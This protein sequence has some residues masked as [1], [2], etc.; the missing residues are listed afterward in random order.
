[1]SSASQAVARVPSKPALRRAGHRPILA[2]ISGHPYPVTA[3]GDAVANAVSR[4][5][6]TS[7]KSNSSTRVP[8]GQSSRNARVS[9]P[10]ASSTTWAQPARVA[11]SS[12]W[13]RN[14]VR[15]ATWSAM[16]AKKSSPACGDTAAHPDRAAAAAARIG[17][18]DQAVGTCVLR[19]TQ[20]GHPQR[21]R[22]HTAELLRK[23][24]LGHDN[25]LKQNMYSVCMSSI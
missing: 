2:Q 14:R 21:G 18:L 22:T 8:A 16:R 7:P 19:D 4:K 15:T 5:A 3:R 24:R 6:N 9:M 1:M 17:V 10:Q 12:L 23:L 20:P 25:L 13:S 11:P